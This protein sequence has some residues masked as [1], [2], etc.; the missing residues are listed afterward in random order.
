[1]KV[2][3]FLTLKENNTWQSYA[4]FL[5]FRIY[6]TQFFDSPPLGVTPICDILQ[7]K[8]V[9]KEARIL[10]LQKFISS[11]FYYLNYSAIKGYLNI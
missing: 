3:V 6:V 2:P 9:N 1:M 8:R 4:T 10:N 11:Y 5:S 7:C